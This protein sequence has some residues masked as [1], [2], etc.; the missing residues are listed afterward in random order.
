MNVQKVF[1]GTM[2]SWDKKNYK[3]DTVLM[4]RRQSVGQDEKSLR[5]KEFFQ[6][7]YMSQGS[8][9]W[10]KN[11]QVTNVLMALVIKDSKTGANS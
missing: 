4:C 8:C 9:P 10:K 11:N 2:Q 7:N 1:E 3:M 5:Q 6:F